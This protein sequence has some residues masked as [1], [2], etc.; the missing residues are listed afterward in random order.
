MN[1][2]V[3]DVETYFYAFILCS[4]NIKTGRKRHFEISSR[5][6]DTQELLA[7]LKSIN[8]QIGYNNINF[9]YPILHWFIN[10]YS[11]YNKY[12]LP[13]AL[14]EQAQ[15][16]IK[17]EFSAIKPKDVLVPQLDLF[18]IWHFNSPARA[19]SLKWLEFAM[20]MENIEDLPYGIYDEL[21]SEMIDEIIDYCYHD[22]DATYK[23]YLES[24]GK[25]SLRKK[26][27]NKYKIPLMN[28]SDVG[29]AESLLLKGYCNKTGLNPYN[30]RKLRSHRKY[31]QGKDVILPIVKFKSDRMNDWLDTLKETY[32]LTPGGTWNGCVVKLYDEEYDIKLGG[33]HCIQK[34]KSFYKR[35][36]MVITERDAASLYPMIISKWGFYP[37]HL[38]P[39]FLELYTEILNERMAAKPLVYNEALSKEERDEYKLIV[40]T[41]KLQLNASYGKMGS[42]L[43]YLYDLKTLYSTTIN[44]QLFMLMLI[45]DLG[46]AGIKVISANTDSVTTYMHEGMESTYRAI[47]AKWQDLTKHTLEDTDYEIIAYRDINNY[48]SKTTDGKIKCKGCFEKDRD[49]NKNHSMMIVPIA[50]QNYYADNKPIEETIKSHVDIF[51]FCKAVK[52][53]GQSTFETRFWTPSGLQSKSLQKRVNRYIVANKG[54]NLIK[55]L[56]ALID[57]NGNNKKDKLN[58]YRKENPNQLDIFNLIEDVVIE[59]DRESEVEAGHQVIMMNKIKKLNTSDYDIN[60]EYYINE[61]YKII[62][63]I[64]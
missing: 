2:E 15:N 52:G 18:R 47:E 60:Y 6:D 49:W 22:V 29:M 25:I 7:H 58:K 12:S 55:I 21:T 51:D 16:I 50:L 24:K 43:S 41:N 13:Q 20:R 46:M 28:S 4:R 57:E 10:N 14:C 3:F 44:N 5:K 38:G 27:T 30:V 9:D 63:Q 23:F 45:E 17:E 32:L 42:D 56:P 39:E 19:T 36:G 59:K 33:I 1:L 64:K 54:V 31:I 11:N 62:N 40:D 26:L 34:A 8:G 35:D 61:C 37:E 48:F 53:I